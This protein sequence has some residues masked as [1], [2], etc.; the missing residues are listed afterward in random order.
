MD[1]KNRD[2]GRGC[3]KFTPTTGITK[4]DVMHRGDDMPL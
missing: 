1:D 4:V 2:K 3:T